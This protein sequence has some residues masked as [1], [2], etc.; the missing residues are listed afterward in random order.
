MPILSYSPHPG[1]PSMTGDWVLRRVDLICTEASSYLDSSRLLHSI[2]PGITRA[3]VPHPPLLPIPPR[4]LAIGPEGTI[5]NRDDPCSRMRESGRRLCR[6]SYDIRLY[7]RGRR[8]SPPCH[9]H[10]LFREDAMS[11]PLRGRTSFRCCSRPGPSRRQTGRLLSNVIRT[12][13]VSCHEIA[14]ECRLCM[15]H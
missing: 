8:V 12:S 5:P 11:P 6:R 2:R 14:D 10:G 1:R 9:S 3:H 15:K 7:F 4:W 13:S